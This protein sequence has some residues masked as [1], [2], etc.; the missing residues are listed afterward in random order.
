MWLAVPVNPS[1]HPRSRQ[2]DITPGAVQHGAELWPGGREN[3][4]SP[5][6]PVRL[7][8]RGRVRIP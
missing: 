5:Y 7:A 4:R 1:R 8:Q 6:T 2:A 3:L